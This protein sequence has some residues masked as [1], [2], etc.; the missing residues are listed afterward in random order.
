LE[1]RP[2]N[3]KFF[4]GQFFSYT[5]A[6]SPW[7]LPPPRTLPGSGVFVFFDE[8]L[9]VDGGHLDAGGSR[10]HDTRSGKDQADFIEPSF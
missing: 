8:H 6:C 7:P 1:T 9:T 3:P 10:Y 5:A 2:Y 4:L